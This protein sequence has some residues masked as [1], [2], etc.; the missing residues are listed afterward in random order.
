MLS[1]D[2]SNS[3]LGPA[4]GGGTKGDAL[5]DAA[6]V[7]VDV[8]P[9]DDGVGVNTFATDAFSGASVQDAGIGVFGAG[10]I[11]ARDEIRDYEPVTPADPDGMT[12]IGDAIATSDGALPTSSYDNVAMVIF[13]DG[14][15]NRPSF[16][17]E[18]TP[19]VSATARI[20]AI[21]LGTPENLDPASLATLCSGNDG[22]L[23]LSAGGGDTFFLL[24]KF[25]LQI[26]AGL[27]NSEIVYDPVG[28]LRRRRDP[29]HPGTWSRAVHHQD[30]GR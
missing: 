28:Q 24:T 22:A 6:E 18:V 29:G 30:T 20:F 7:F 17:S 9:D 8:I 12:S 2:K 3:M 10:R 1:L 16:I 27:T 4:A 21:G 15:E 26:L 19:L 11:A 23:L 14:M 25:Y 5:R 13:T